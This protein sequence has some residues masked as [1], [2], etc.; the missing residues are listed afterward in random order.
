MT[1]E[2]IQ[3]LRARL[4]KAT[5]AEMTE[6]AEDP[7]EVALWHRDPLIRMAKACCDVWANLVWHSER[8]DVPKFRVIA[9]PIPVEGFDGQGNPIILGERDAIEFVPIPVMQDGQQVTKPVGG[10][11]RVLT[12]DAIREPRYR[13]QLMVKPTSVAAIRGHGDPSP[14]LL[15]KIT[16]DLVIESFL[17]DDRGPLASVLLTLHPRTGAYQRPREQRDLRRCRPTG[18]ADRVL[19]GYE[20]NNPGRVVNHALGQMYRECLTRVGERLA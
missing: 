18:F 9:R 11:H 19:D 2:Q 12:S 8:F 16:V 13:E 17:E 6:I 14:Q 5:G 10:D 15:A 3:E 1:N 20:G 4:E 7:K